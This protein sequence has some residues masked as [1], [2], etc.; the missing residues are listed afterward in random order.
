MKSQD[1]EDLSP[2]VRYSYSYTPISMTE[3]ELQDYM[4][5]LCECSRQVANVIM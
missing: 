2:I 3:S 5:E 4:P 1:Y